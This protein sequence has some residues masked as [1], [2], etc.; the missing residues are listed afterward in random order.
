LRCAVISSIKGIV[1]I[2]LV[3]E[4]QTGNTVVALLQFFILARC[5]D[6]NVNCDRLRLTV[7]LHY[8]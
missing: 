5:F 1:L 7:A 3:G 4:C 2:H 8:G 6:L